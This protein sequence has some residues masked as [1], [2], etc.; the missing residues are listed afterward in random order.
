MTVIGRRTAERYGI[1]PLGFTMSAGVGEAGLRGLQLGRL[2]ELLDR[3]VHDEGRARCSSRTRRCAG[4][5]RARAR[6]G[7]RSR[8]ACRRHRLRHADAH[9]RPRCASSR[10][11]SRC[12]CIIYRLAMVRG[13]VNDQ[14]PASFIVDTGGEVISISTAM[15]IRHRAEPDAAHSAEGV[16]QLG[17]GSRRVPVPGARPGLRSHPLRQL[18]DRRAEPAGTER[19]ARHRARRHRRPPVPEPL[20]RRH[21]PRS[22]D[23]SGCLSFLEGALCLEACCPPRPRFFRAPTLRDR[24]QNERRHGQ[25]VARRVDR[26]EGQIGAARHPPH[27][28]Q[29]LLRDRRP[30]ALRAN[31]RTRR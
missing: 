25:P 24:F 15:A 21:R 31:A 8:S 20:P 26:D 16:R 30:P 7:R 18:R 2:D 17:L 10:A 6:A 1:Q 19:A 29:R 4:C 9:V 3:H 5:R 22:R 12:R 28:R 11:S 13:T 14:E 27:A 23:C